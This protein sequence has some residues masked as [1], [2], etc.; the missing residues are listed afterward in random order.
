MFSLFNAFEFE[1]KQ[2]SE[3]LRWKLKD[4]NRNLL[5]NLGI[6]I[7]VYLVNTRAK[8]MTS[9][10]EAVTKQCQITKLFSV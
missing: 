7:N 9:T 6:Y 1:L 4:N 10:E 8:L 2:N 5:N 3:Q